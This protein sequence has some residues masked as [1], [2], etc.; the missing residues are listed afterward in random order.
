MKR[1]R[2]IIILIIS[3]SMMSCKD[4]VN[5]RMLK[6]NNFIISVDFPDTVVINK[7]YNGKIN[8]ANDLDTITTS[9]NDVK[10]Y[11]FIDYAFLRTNTVNYNETHL[12]TIVTD[13]FTSETNRVIPL[14]NISFDKLGVN[15]LDGIITDEVAIE[16]G[17]KD[18]NGKPMTRIITDEF[19][20][21][22]KVVVI[23][24]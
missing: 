13:T 12:K 14:Y 15:Y 19:R 4:E 22:H 24:K 21:T 6:P 20:V 18:N 1:N 3:V 10:K 7:L 23:N 9:L 2:F 11:R 16:N 8:Y 5:T 17:A